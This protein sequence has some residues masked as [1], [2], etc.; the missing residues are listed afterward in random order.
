MA[1]VDG[2][3][4]EITLVGNCMVSLL[5]EEGFHTVEFRYENEALRLGSMI[6]AGC[7]LVFIVVIVTDVL[8]R[9]RK[10]SN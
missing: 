2:E 9:R 1:Y 7:C 4:A 6:T 3:K 8:L 5:L 10:K